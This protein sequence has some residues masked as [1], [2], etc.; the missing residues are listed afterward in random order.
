MESGFA[1]LAGGRGAICPSSSV[2]RAHVDRLSAQEHIGQALS[3]RCREHQ[4]DRDELQWWQGNADRIAKRMGKGE[5]AAKV[6]SIAV[7]QLDAHH[8]HTPC[9]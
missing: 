9:G 6:T 8:P 1:K 2:S 3:A 5:A 7:L 4:D